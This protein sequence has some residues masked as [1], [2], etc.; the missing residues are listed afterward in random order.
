[1]ERDTND[2]RPYLSPQK[3]KDFKNVTRKI[4]IPFLEEKGVKTVGNINTK[5]YSDYK[6]HLVKK[7]YAAGYINNT[8]LNA[9]NRILYFL[10][11]YEYC[12]RSRAYCGKL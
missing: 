6:E 8:L 5:L 7:G 4:L 10:V 9:F 12:N 2:N 1:M 3:I 11:R